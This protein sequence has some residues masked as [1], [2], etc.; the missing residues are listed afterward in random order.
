VTSRHDERAREFGE[1]VSDLVFAPAGRL[2]EL[3]RVELA[4]GRVLTF[5]ARD[6]ATAAAIADGVV[7]P[8]L[9]RAAQRD[10]RAGRPAPLP[11]T[12]EELRAATVEYFV[13]RCRSITRDN[14]RGTLPG[15][16][17][18]D[19]AVVKVELVTR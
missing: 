19:Q 18:E 13:E 5:G 11:L 17:P 10:L 6:L 1:A 14:V 15:R 4:D 12:L 8:T 9:A 16:I 3:L 2:A 7:R